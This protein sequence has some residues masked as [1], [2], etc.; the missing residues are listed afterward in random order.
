MF[1]AVNSECLV[2]GPLPIETLVIP[3][4]CFMVSTFLK[5]SGANSSQIITTEPGVCLTGDG[6]SSLRLQTSLCFQLVSPS[7]MASY[8][9]F[10]AYGTG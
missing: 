6:P 10:V 3:V 9:D 8:L 1:T 7:A 5:S 4:A 2:A